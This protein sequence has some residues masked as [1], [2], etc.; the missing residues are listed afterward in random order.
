MHIIAFMKYSN[1]SLLYKL[2]NFPL[3]NV[4]LMHIHA[5]YMYFCIYYQIKMAVFVIKFL[6]AVLDTERGRLNSQKTMYKST[7]RLSVFQFFSAW[8]LI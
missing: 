1:I 2:N 8:K 5:L 3:V 7:E 6:I 4:N